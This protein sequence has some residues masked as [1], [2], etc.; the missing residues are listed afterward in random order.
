MR[1]GEDSMGRFSVEFEVANAIDVALASQRKLSPGKVRRLRISGV[2][3]PGATRLVLPASV[4]K[5]LGVPKVDRITVRYADR[6]KLQRDRVGQI[7]VT[8]QGRTGLFDAIV[9]PKRQTALIGAIVLE[10]LDFL[11]D[12]TLQKLVPR[13]PKYIISEAE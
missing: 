5:A 11:V 13:D 2:V 1:N 4:V 10:S 8:L 12:C 6:R 7:D 9:E 3:D